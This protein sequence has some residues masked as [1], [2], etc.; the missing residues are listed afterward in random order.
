MWRAKQMYTLSLLKLLDAH[1]KMLRLILLSRYTGEQQ[2]LLISRDI[3]AR[4]KT[5]MQG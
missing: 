4:S 5:S 2:V 1:G 3:T